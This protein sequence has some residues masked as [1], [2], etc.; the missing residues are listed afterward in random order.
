M[1]AITGTP[2]T[3]K[4][5]VARIISKRLGLPL[6]EANA[7]IRTKRLYTHREGGSMVVDPERLRRA[8]SGFEGVAEGHLLCEF[9]LPAKC[10]VL[11][12]SP[13]AIARRLAPR[14]YG[15]QKLRDNIEAEALDYC[16]IM[17]RKHYRRVIEVDTTGLSPVQSAAKALRYLTGGTDRVD[18]SSYF[19]TAKCV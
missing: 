15:A 4:T 10:I 19:L 9:P 3:G 2:G 12:A 6:I 8:L 17:A 13:R 5:S 16:A 11:R 7:L 18:W 14:N 1:I